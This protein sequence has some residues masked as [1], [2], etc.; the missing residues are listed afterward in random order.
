MLVGQV[1]VSK[2]FVGR[3][4]PIRD[5]E[6]VDRSN[7]PGVYSVY[8]SVETKHRSAMSEGELKGT[9]AVAFFVIVVAYFFTPNYF[10]ISVSFS[11]RKTWLQQNTH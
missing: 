4:M 7:Y 3:S 9:T 5:G 2:V 10:Y 11:F 6:P 8:R 1:N